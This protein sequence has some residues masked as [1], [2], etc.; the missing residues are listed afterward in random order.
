MWSSNLSQGGFSIFPCA[1]VPGCVWEQLAST[2]FCLSGQLCLRFSCFWL[3]Q[4][5]GEPSR[6]QETWMVPMPTQSTV[7][8]CLFLSSLHSAEFHALDLHLFHTV[9]GL[10]RPL[11]RLLG[12]CVAGLSCVSSCLADRFLNGLLE[13]S[14]W[15]FQ[16][17]PSGQA[18]SYVPALLFALPCGSRPW[19]VQQDLRTRDI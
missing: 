16:L 19:P 1:A 9:S 4:V 13:A 17:R 15:H 18:F 3:Q 7:F 10:V 8:L 2:R 5:L 11:S 14:W 6:L 12:S